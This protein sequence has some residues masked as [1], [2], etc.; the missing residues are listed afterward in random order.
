[1]LGKICGV[2]DLIGADYIILMAG[3]VGY[4]ILC[5]STQKHFAIG[6]KADLHIH[7]YVKEDQI[8]LFGFHTV[9]EKYLFRALLTVDGVG[10]K[11]AMSIIDN[12]SLYEINDAVMKKDSKVFRAISGVG[13]KTAEKIAID[14]QNKLG[15]LGGVESKKKVFSFINNSKKDAQ[16]ALVALGYNKD[17]IHKLL[18]NNEYDDL[19]TTDI[20]KKAL[21]EVCTF[22]N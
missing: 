16:D 18:S 14:L 10:P 15:F 21:Q 8:K 9:E 7:T 17:M 22:N 3:Y 19:N 20:I 5:N 2:V 12:I 1:M 4:E 6:E 13:P 11:T